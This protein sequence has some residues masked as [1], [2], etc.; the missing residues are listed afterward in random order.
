MERLRQAPLPSQE[1]NTPPLQLRPQLVVPADTLV[2]RLQVL[3][4]PGL[5]QQ[6]VHDLMHARSADP[7]AGEPPRVRA[8]VMLD[9]LEDE[10]MCELTAT[11]GSRVGAIAL[12]VLMELGFPYALEVTPS[13]LKRARG[14]P[15]LV[16]PRSVKAGLGVAGLNTLVY[17]SQTLGDFIEYQ[18]VSGHPGYYYRLDALYHRID[19]ASMGMPVFVALLLGPAMLSGLTWWLRLRAPRP[20][21]NALQWLVGV[22]FMTLGFTG[23]VFGLRLTHSEGLM[24]LSGLLTLVSAWLLRPRAEPGGEPDVLPSA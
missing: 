8:D 5:T 23:G 18:E 1:E 7:P 15:P 9:I 16:I 20:F 12:E 2:Q 6:E 22:A 24:A 14:R 10:R 17:A 3:R 21:F 11:D 19:D 4:E 13:M